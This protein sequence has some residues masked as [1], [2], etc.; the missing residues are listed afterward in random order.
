MPPVGKFTAYFANVSCHSAS[1]HVICISGLFYRLCCSFNR[2]D[3]L[4]PRHRC[5]PRFRGLGLHS[6]LRDYLAR[7]PVISHRIEFRIRLSLSL[8]LAD[9][10]FASSCSPRSDYAAAV[11]FH[12]RTSDL[13]PDGDFHPDTLCALTV[14]HRG[15]DGGLAPPLPPN[16]TGGFPASGFPVSDFPL[17]I[18]AIELEVLLG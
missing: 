14:A 18:E 7:S 3:W 17:G 13:D 1:N 12:Y 5:R 6:R 16:R 10:Q 11:T 2:T 8:V 15:R 9:W 4:V